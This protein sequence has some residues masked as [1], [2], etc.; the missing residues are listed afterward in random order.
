MKLFTISE[1]FAR[2]KYSEIIA[3]DLRALI[4]DEGRPGD[5][6]PSEHVLLERYG[7]SRPTLREALRILEVE[8]LVKIR[9]GAQGGAVIREPSIEVMTRTFGVYLQQHGTPVTD[10]INARMVIEPVAARLAALNRDR[11]LSE[12]EAVLVREKVVV[13][14]RSEAIADTEAAFHPAL[15][16]G[17]FLA[18]A[19]FAFGV[20][21]QNLLFSNSRASPS[22]RR[23]SSRSG[24]RRSLRATPPSTTSPWRW[25]WSE[26]WPWSWCGSPGSAG[27]CQPSGTLPRPKVSESTRPRA[28]RWCSAWRLSSRPSPGA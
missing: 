10:V 28:G 16:S 5:Y 23:P 25:W 15:L 9:R 24:G 3:D 1:P 20:L 2:A 27:F 21:A 18:L 17:L 14:E 13:A 7:V 22:E 11:D 4:V 12:M 8:G 19:T 6:L 26:S